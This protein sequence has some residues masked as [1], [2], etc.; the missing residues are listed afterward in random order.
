MRTVDYFGIGPIDSLREL[1]GRLS[2]GTPSACDQCLRKFK[3]RA[4]TRIA[5]NP[6][7][8]IVCYTTKITKESQPTELNENFSCSEICTNWSNSDKAQVGEP[9]TTLESY[10]LGWPRFGAYLILV[11]STLT[12]NPKHCIVCYTTK[13]TKGSVCRKR[14]TVGY[15]PKESAKPSI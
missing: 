9:L 15:C 8:C 5:C 1:S 3:T 6:K 14:F 13:I 10:P 11:Q 12:C 2:N 7:H 4:E